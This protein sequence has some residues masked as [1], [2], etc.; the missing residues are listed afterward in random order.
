MQNH[1]PKHLFVQRVELLMTDDCAVSDHVVALAIELT[2]VGCK[3]IIMLTAGHLVQ[4]CPRF[5][6]GAG[7]SAA[8]GL[9]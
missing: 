9:H 1:A 4:C 6:D 5:R 8:Q 3:G 2:R 7:T